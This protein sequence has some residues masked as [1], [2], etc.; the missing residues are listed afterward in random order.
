M[1]LA[2][3]VSV[4]SGSAA[5]ALA[6]GDV[7]DGR[8]PGPGVASRERRGSPP[9]LRCGRSIRHERRTPAPEPGG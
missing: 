1:R 8:Q 2:E 3:T 9:R 5:P 6:E 4:L 7:V